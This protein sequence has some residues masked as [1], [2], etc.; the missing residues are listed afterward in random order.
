M[1]LA[2]A[3]YNAVVKENSQLAEQLEERQKEI[4]LLLADKARLVNEKK[5]MQGTL[6]G[7]E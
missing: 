7:G 4:D 3:N 1:M 2:I 5:Q 6:V